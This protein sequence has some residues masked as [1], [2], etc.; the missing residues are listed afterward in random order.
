MQSEKYVADV[1]DLIAYGAGVLIFYNL[2][3]RRRYG[4]ARNNKAS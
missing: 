1:Y 3:N 2:I 4:V